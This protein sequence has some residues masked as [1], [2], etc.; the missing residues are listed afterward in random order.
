MSSV[1]DTE[2]ASAE[3]RCIRTLAGKTSQEQFCA[4]CK[5]PTIWRKERIMRNTTASIKSAPSRTNRRK[6]IRLLV[7]ATVLIMQFIHGTATATESLITTY[8][9]DGGWVEHASWT[10]TL[11]E[12]QHIQ[13]LAWSW[14][15]EFSPLHVQFDNVITSDGLLDDFDDGTINTSI[16]ITAES[17]GA[18]LEETGGVLDIDVPTGPTSTGE[19]RCGGVTS[20]DT[21]HGNW[22]VQV[23]FSLNAEYHVTPNTSASLCIKDQSD[24]GVD[25]WIHSGH[26][27]SRDLLQMTHHIAETPTDHLAGKLRITRTI[28]IVAVEIDI[29]PGSYPNSINPKARGV[30]PVAILTTEDFDAIEV[31]PSTVALEGVLAKEKGKSGKYGSVEDVDADGD[32]DLVV[33]IPNTI[34]WADDVTEATLTGNLRAKYEGYPIE[35]SDS[36]RLVP[37]EE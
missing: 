28:I 22:D 26:Y 29:K 21:L 35:G 31:D 16:W 3:R 8:Y 25:I 2:R 27:V 7:V 34:D 15:P 17:E 18:A 9:W 36:V 5:V 20:K 10:T 23:D 37:P 30:I 14:Q 33:Q 6:I 32:L 12:D 1:P 4:S 11:S 24:H 13:I 19:G